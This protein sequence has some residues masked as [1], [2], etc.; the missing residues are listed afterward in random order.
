MKAAIYNP[1]IDTL[2]GG[3]RYSLGFAIALAKASYDV[4]I[5]WKDASVLARLE[6]RFGLDLCKIRAVNDI[7][8]GEGYDILFW[9]SDGSVPILHARDNY[10]HFQVPFHDVNGGSL[11]NRMKFMRVKKVICNS[12][13]TKS[14]IDEEYKV[15]STVIYP[16]VSV[17]HFKAKR[18]ENIIFYLGRFSKLKQAKGQ[19]ILIEAFKKFYDSGNKTFSMILAGGVEVGVDDSYMDSLR[20]RS[21]E[22]PIQIMQSPTHS[23]ILDLYGRAKYYWSASGYGVDETKN[24]ENVEHFGITVVEAMASKTIPLVY[25]AGGHKEIIKNGQNGYLWRT[26]DEL[27]DITQKLEKDK[28]SYAYLKDQTY[29][30]SW[31]YEVKNFDSKVH[32]LIQINKVK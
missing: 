28:K 20:K 12:K 16:P 13:F 32:E 3:E 10:I 31:N 7:K 26:I 11:I 21:E 17:D 5:Q 24:P 2:G 9:V 29:K 8:R 27:I 18:K 19:E 1:Y 23:Q 22:Y 14:V 15:D 4:D 30:D 25:S 6:K